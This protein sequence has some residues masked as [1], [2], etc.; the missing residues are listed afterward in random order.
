MR[1]TTKMFYDRFLSDMQKNMEAIFKNQEQIS[2]GKKINRPSDDPTAMSRIIA[3][4]TQITAFDEYKRAIDTANSNIEA[5]DKVLLDLSDVLNRSKELALGGANGITTSNDRTMIAKEVSSL[6]E[7]VIDIANTKVGDR[8]IFS[9]YKSNIAPIDKN[10]GEFVGDANI[11][12]VDINPDMGIAVNIPASELFSFKKLNPNDSDNAI[13]PPYNWDISGLYVSTDEIYEDADPNGALYTGGGFT[14]T[15]NV[16]SI[17]GGTLTI[18]VGDDATTSVNV[19]ISANATLANVRD[20]INNANA[21]VKA[22][23]VNIGTTANP[24][25]RIVVASNPAGRPGDVRITATSDD[26]AG[27][28]L[29]TLVYMSTSD[30]ITIDSTN[31]KIDIT[32]GA[33]SGTAIIATG[34]YTVDTLARAVKTAL[35]GATASNNTYTVAYDSTNK[36][37]KIISDDTNTDTLSLLWS[38]ANTTAKTVL[39]FDAVDTTGIT[40]GGSD[41][42]DNQLTYSIQNQTL[43]TNIT[44]YNYI[45]DPSNSNYYSFNNNYLNENNVLRAIHFLKASLENNDPGRIQKALDYISKVSEKLYQVQAEVG[46]R[47]NKLE[48]EEKYQDDRKYDITTYLSNDQDADIAKAVSDMLQRQTAL[49]GLRTISS[50]ILKSSL[51]DFLK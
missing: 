51:F 43:G 3:Y 32:E 48:T 40:A 10:T 45:T 35:E 12:K 38:N 31:N 16:F 27:T 5:M 34:T 29:H 25:Y 20:A 8:Y 28:G 22:E 49:D 23:V 9:G 15:T 11:V 2:T 39:G 7:H 41:T 30:V 4:K 6:L 33:L 50:N 26:A 18:K 14:S 1:I 19:T 46:S 13:L 42:S 36:K 44:N 17:K 24:D 21:G 37:F 47:G